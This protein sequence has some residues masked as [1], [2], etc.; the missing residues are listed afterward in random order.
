LASAEA[1]RR[2]ALHA[3]DVALKVSA[4]IPVRRSKFPDDPDDAA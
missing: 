1:E 3:R 2:A 4:A